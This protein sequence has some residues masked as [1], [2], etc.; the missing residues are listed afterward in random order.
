M[1]K[2]QKRCNLPTYVYLC[3]KCGKQIELFQKISERCNPLCNSEDC[4]DEEMQI[5]IQPVRFALNGNGWA[6]DGYGGKK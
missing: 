1:L 5:V 2:A 4:G 3:K 6:R